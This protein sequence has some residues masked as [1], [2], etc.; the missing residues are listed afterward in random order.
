MRDKRGTIQMKLPRFLLM[1]RNMPHCTMTETPTMLM[2]E[3]Q[4]RT[5]L[6]LVKPNIRQTVESHQAKQS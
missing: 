1:Y 5:R 4:L 2:M 3:R 6:D